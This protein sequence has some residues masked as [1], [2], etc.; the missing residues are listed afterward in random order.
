MIWAGIRGLHPSHLISS[1]GLP[2][3]ADI[4]NPEPLKR[5]AKKALENGKSVASAAEAR[6][7]TA[8]DEDS[9]EPPVTRSHRAKATSSAPA[10]TSRRGR[11]SKAQLQRAA[12]DAARDPD[13]E[14]EDAD[15]TF[16]P[17]AAVAETAEHDEHVETVDV[18]EQ[19][20]SG[21]VAWG[22]LVLGGL[23]VG[24]AGVCGAEII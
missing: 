12:E 10:T 6:L 23:G 13:S 9:D 1:I 19:A 22:V 18:S 3:D 15:P 20:E 16:R 8:L 4:T 5:S 2:V 17:T 11:P 7:R 21:A 14:D 24:M